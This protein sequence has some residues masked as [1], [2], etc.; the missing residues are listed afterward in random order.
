M[1]KYFL[2]RKSNHVV[3]F[4]NNNQT[5]LRRTPI[6]ENETERQVSGGKT[7][8]DRVQWRA[9]VPVEERVQREPV[10]DGAKATG[11]GQRAGP[12]RGPNK[13]MVPEQARQDQEVERVEEPAGLAAHGAGTLQP[14]HRGHV[15]RRDG[16]SAGRDVYLSPTSAA[17]SSV[18]VNVT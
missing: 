4:V 1:F 2:L 12:E 17:R 14:H 8:P 7:A 6:A 3:R 16:G 5:F 18:Q 9:V 13:D 10:L 11:T 15:R